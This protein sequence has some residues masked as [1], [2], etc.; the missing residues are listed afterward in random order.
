[1]IIKNAKFCQLA[2]VFSG[3]K[4]N[5]KEDIIKAGEEALVCL[6]NGAEKDDLNS[7]RYKRYCDKVKRD[8]KAVEAKKLPP[9][10]TAARYHSLRVFFQTQEWK[11]DVLGL[12][13]SKMGL[14]RSWG[15]VVAKHNRPAGG[16]KQMLEMF[17][18]KCKTG[19][20]T[21]RCTCLR[22]GL[23]FS[24]ACS[25]CEGLSCT[26]IEILVMSDIDIDIDNED[27]DD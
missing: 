11:G 8:S 3:N 12:E 18:C 6:L 22:H 26:N 2:Q 4:D 25:N 15:T 27:E 1:M 20:S 14:G 21:L 9:T 17:R 19:C 10:S 13:P 5:P 24:S 23:L 7:L 16:T